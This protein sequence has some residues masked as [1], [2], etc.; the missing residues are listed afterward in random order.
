MNSPSPL[1]TYDYRAEIDQAIQETHQAIEEAF[2][3]I[4]RQEDGPVTMRHALTA[5]DT[6]LS[7]IE[8]EVCCLVGTVDRLHTIALKLLEQRDE[9][10]RQRDLL[11]A[12][13]GLTEYGTD[14][15]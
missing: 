4:E 3:Y 12:L 14:Q 2:G 1:Q 5:I 8:T 10:L 13:T 6:R 15:A 7:A 11:I 9:A